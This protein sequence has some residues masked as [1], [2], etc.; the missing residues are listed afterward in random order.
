MHG[1]YTGERGSSIFGRGKI[2]CVS[3]DRTLA[4]MRNRRVPSTVARIKINNVCKADSQCW[5]TVS[6]QLTVGLIHESL[7]DGVWQQF[8]DSGRTHG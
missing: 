4:S 7:T 5:H 2:R 6:I 3:S 1:S 8:L